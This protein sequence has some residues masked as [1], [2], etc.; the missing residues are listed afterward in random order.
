MDDHR[1]RSPV[2][3]TAI[4]AD[5]FAS[6]LATGAVGFAGPASADSAAVEASSETDAVTPTATP[7]SAATNSTPTPTPDGS[8]AGVITTA[9]D[10]TTETIENTTDSVTNTTDETVE[11]TTETVEN[12]TE[13][14]ENTT[15][16]AVE[17]T[18][19]TT[20]SVVNE[21]GETVE[22]TTETVEN[23]TEDLTNTTENVTS[24][25]VDESDDL[26]DAN[27]T[28]TVS[29][30]LN[31]TVGVNASVGVGSGT[32]TVT[33]TTEASPTPEST[34][35]THGDEQA[36]G[37][38]TPTV[39]GALAANGGDGSDA[40]DSSLP[41]RAGAA[42]GG[43]LV[44][45]G[46]TVAAAS[47]HVAANTTAAQGGELAWL[48]QAARLKAHGA[49][50]AVRGRLARLPRILF[51]PGYSRHD[52]S[53]P[54]EHETRRDLFEAVERSPGVNLSTLADDSDVSLSTVR[55]HLRILQEEHLIVGERIRGQRRYFPSN[56]SEPVL[57]AALDDSA[58][59]PILR[60]LARSGA[61]SVS[62]LADALGRDPS[63]ISHHV[64]R[65]EDDGLVERERDRRSV[66]N[67]L[68][69]VAE[70]VLAQSGSAGGQQRPVATE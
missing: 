20:E 63:T 45:A 14:T 64:S 2:A 52:D 16:S 22:N 25:I 6:L 7:S 37:S 44:V 53:D 47:K 48:G 68:A 13:S 17:T 18:E 56:E 46:V 66:Q 50:D 24:P 40:G 65:L 69:P 23:T 28:A 61:A 4:L 36:A 59:E 57:V 10:N 55:H 60:T 51:P 19:N 33:P 9:T 38:G 70:R 42:A 67:S 26:V 39:S 49:I 8:L 43:A 21:T 11:N 32:A 34:A 12:T 5:V 54:L 1:A 27:L 58:T 41:S 15:D 35:R 31:A 3:A 62:D 29:G 30:S